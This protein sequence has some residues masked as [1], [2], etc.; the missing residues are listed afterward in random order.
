VGV[1]GGEVEVTAASAGAAADAAERL[2]VTEGG[3]FNAANSGAVA[4][5]E[6]IARGVIEGLGAGVGE[7]VAAGWSKE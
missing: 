3:I 1:S 6:N 7:G 4:V 5:G 2:L